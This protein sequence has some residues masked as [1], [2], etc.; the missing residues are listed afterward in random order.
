MQPA[1]R[2]SKRGFAVSRYLADIIRLNQDDLAMF[3]ASAEV[4]LPGGKPPAVGQ[5]IVRADYARTLKA[6]AAEG[7]DALYKGRKSVRW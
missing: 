1:I 5:T 3:P 2:Y 4:F 7:P 6:V